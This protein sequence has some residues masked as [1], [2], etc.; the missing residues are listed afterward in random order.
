MTTT[1]DITTT[2]RQNGRLG[3]RPRNTYYVSC[4]GDDGNVRCGG[5]IKTR[6]TTDAG[7]VAAARS[8]VWRGSPPASCGYILRA[9]VLDPDNTDRARTIAA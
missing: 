2:A 3:S 8:Q 5:W 6:A 1:S 4:I 9:I 7:I